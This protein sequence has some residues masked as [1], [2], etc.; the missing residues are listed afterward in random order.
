MR[1]LKD[2]STLGRAVLLPGLLQHLFEASC[3]DRQVPSGL[4][5][6]APPRS[7]GYTLNLKGF[8][9]AL[10]WRG[11]GCMNPQVSRYRKD[12]HQH[13]YRD[14]RYCLTLFRLKIRCLSRSCWPRADLIGRSLRCI[15]Y[16]PPPFIVN[17]ERYELQVRSYELK[18]ENAINRT[19]LREEP[20]Q[21]KKIPSHFKTFI[22]SCLFWELGSERIWGS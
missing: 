6:V 13:F 1:I 15:G 4:C 19:T 16:Q 8:M 14:P 3:L 12:G 7:Q 5:A 9:Q 17:P 2:A 11:V 22:H 10:L 20:V 18:F 21:N